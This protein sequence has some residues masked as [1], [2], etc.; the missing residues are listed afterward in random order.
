MKEVCRRAMANQG[1]IGKKLMPI[2]TVLR[3]LRYVRNLVRAFDQ[4][5]CP[6]QPH[7]R[8]LSGSC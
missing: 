8:F 6:K 4:G 7:R 1:R 5:K 3:S 2:F